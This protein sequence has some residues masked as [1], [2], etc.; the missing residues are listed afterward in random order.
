MTATFEIPEE[1]AAR[2]REAANEKG[3][4]LAE[5]VADALLREA[6]RVETLGHDPS[7]SKPLSPEEWSRKFHELVDSFKDLNLPPIPPEAWRR[8]NIY[9]DRDS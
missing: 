2:L 5:L 1:V 8:E 4:S 3:I 6:V 9:E 7:V